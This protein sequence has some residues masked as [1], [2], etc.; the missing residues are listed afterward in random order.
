M[1]ARESNPMKGQESTDRSTDKLEVHY[2]IQSRAAREL[3]GYIVERE[4]EEDIDLASIDEWGDL[5]HEPR[6]VDE[7]DSTRISGS[8]HG[9]H[10][11][12]NLR[13]DDL[14]ERATAQVGY[15]VDGVS[16]GLTGEGEDTRL[17]LSLLA[18]F[19]VDEARRL[20]HA[21]LLAAEELERW[22]AVSDAAG[23]DRDD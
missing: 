19:D 12:I 20:A 5:S 17:G 3:A 7:C 2:E 9:T 8:A 22:S 13:A 14:G 15:S 6:R 21:L 11:S 23:D 18:G 10:A 1:T 16:L 4:R